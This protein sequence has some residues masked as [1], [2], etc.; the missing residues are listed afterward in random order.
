MK[1]HS[2]KA[3]RG[4]RGFTLA[5]VLVTLAILSVLAAVLLPALNN[6]LSKGDAG[7]VAS[8]LGALQTGA[9]AFLSDVHR[10]PGQITHLTTKITTAMSDVSPQAYPQALVDK[11]KGP[12]LGKTI[13]GPTSIGT[14][15]N[16]LTKTSTNTN[17]IDYLTVTITDVQQSDF[18]RLEE[19]L[20]EGANSSTS[21]TAGIV[22]Y[23]GTSVLF[24]ALPIQ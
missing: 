21:S 17:S 5:E 20:D 11:W 1:T 23:S 10:Y 13:V 24:L 4:R 18:A 2:M 3:R 12:Y 8:D 22:R 9:Q 15:S 6:Q 16:V 19:M 7:R 14:I